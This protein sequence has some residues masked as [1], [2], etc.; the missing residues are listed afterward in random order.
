MKLPLPDMR[1]RSLNRLLLYFVGILATCSVLPAVALGQKSPTELVNLILTSTNDTERIAASSLLINTVPATSEGMIA[2]AVMEDYDNDEDEVIKTC[3]EILSQNPNYLPALMLL[4]NSLEGKERL[5]LWER[6]LQQEPSYLNYSALKGEYFAL[7]AEN[8]K[9]AEDFLNK[10]QQKLPNAYVFDFINGMA[11]ERAGQ[12]SEAEHFYEQA[13]SKGPD[14]FELYVRL[15]IL[16]TRNIKATSEE[17]ELKN[18]LQPVLQFAQLH[19]SSP[20]PWLF[21]GLRMLEAARTA[22]NSERENYS[23]MFGEKPNSQ[24]AFANFKRAFDIK[25]VAEY[26]VLAGETL[27]N[28]NVSHKRAVEVQQQ[29]Y[30]FMVGAQKKLPNDQLLTRYLGIHLSVFKNDS[31]SAASLFQQAIKDSQTVNDRTANV[32][33]LGRIYSDLTFEYDKGQA[34]FRSY[35]QNGGKK[36]DLFA[37]LYANRRDAGDFK[38][39]LAQLDDWEKY[40]RTILKQ[41]FDE[42]SVLARRRQIGNFLSPEQQSENFYRD[43]PFLNLWREKIGSQVLSINYAP[44][45]ASIPEKDYDLLSHAASLLKEQGANKYI[46]SIEGHADE[47][48]SDKTLSL[49]RSELVAQHFHEKFGIE[50]KRMQREGLGSDYPLDQT[51]DGRAKNR[52]VEILAIGN[53]SKPRISTTGALNADQVIALSPDG[54][55]L[56]TGN[57][58]IQLWDTREQIKL[59]DLGRGGEMLKFS[60]NGRY[61]ATTLDY[62]EVGGLKTDALIIYDVKTGLTMHQVPWSPL[63]VDPEASE[64][65]HFDWDPTSQRIV[66]TTP[67]NRIVI[68]DLIAKCNVKQRLA[69]G[70]RMNGG[71]PVLW[72]RDGKYIIAGRPAGSEL[73]VYNA[74]DLS[75]VKELPGVYWPHALAQTRDGKYI[76]ASSQST[77]KCSELLTVWNAADWSMRQLDIPVL[78]D[79]IAV[80]PGKHVVALNDF[81]CRCGHGMTCP[82]KTLLIDLDDLKILAEH[83][84]G[85]VAVQNS[86]SADGK[87]IYQVYED[88]IDLLDAG[89]PTLALVA[90]MK[91]L[92]VRP[93]GSSADLRNGHFLSADDNGF[94]VWSVVTGK[95]VHS[96]KESVKSFG[97][98]SEAPDVFLAVSED[99]VA[100]K[101]KILQFNTGEFAEKELLTLDFEVDKWFS[102]S[103]I[104]VFAGKPFLPLYRGALKGVVETYERRTM[105][106]RNRFEVPLVTVRQLEYDGVYDSGIVGLS[107]N[108][109]GTEISVST[110]WQDGF[111]HAPTS[112]SFVQRFDATTGKPAGVKR[113]SN[114]GI[115]GI[116]YVNGNDHQLAITTLLTTY[117]YDNP[118]DT[119]TPQKPRRPAGEERIDLKGGAQIRWSNGFLRYS[120]PAKGI[121]KEWSFN[122]NLVGVEVFEDRN[123]LVTLNNANE[124]SFFDLAKGEQ[125]LT[126]LSKNNDEWIAYTPAGE[127]LASPNGT[128]KVFWSLGDRNL[129]F[130]ALA[131]LNEK[132]DILSQKL[133]LISNCASTAKEPPEI[134]SLIEPPYSVEVLSPLSSQGPD[135]QYRLVLSVE[136]KEKNLPEPQFSFSQG[137][138]DLTQ[139][140]GT[141]ITKRPNSEVYDVER[142]FDLRDGKNDL[143]VFLNYRKT[144]QRQAHI[145]VRK[146]PGGGPAGKGD[147]WFLGIGVK[148]YKNQSDGLSFP[149]DDVRMIGDELQ[150]Q[151]SLGLYR[152]V[153][154]QIPPEN[155]VDAVRITTE[156]ANIQEKAQEND[157]VLIYLSGHGV[158]GAFS[159]VMFIPYNHDLKQPADGGVDMA[160]FHR[161]LA[162]PKNLKRKTMLWLDICR[163]GAT[164]EDRYLK[165]R[166]RLTDNDIYREVNG[167]TTIVFSSTTGSGS[168]T[169]GFPPT[170]KNGYFAMAILE[171]LTGSSKPVLGA[172]TG[173]FSPWDLMKYVMSRVP[174]AS[175]SKQQPS[176]IFIKNYQDW[177]FAVCPLKARASSSP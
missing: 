28:S 60:P 48:E 168:A 177:P 61:L 169:E 91:G 153:H 84:V 23:K 161:F 105:T 37:A 7:E 59:R 18:C 13:I 68:Y 45:S 56:A 120:M 143:E 65:S 141:K 34:L 15:A 159:A 42:E 76:V 172:E 109:K 81:G 113:L 69:P 157:T 94:H 21:I 47:T 93:I 146:T 2:R 82:R 173:K 43:N 9:V 133:D 55:L 57:Y 126:I 40:G 171:A 107:A 163:G 67:P 148:T 110:Y 5:E 129:E 85:E 33:S 26:A 121:T 149:V 66:Y 49:Q 142:V 6:I 35:L 139:P 31:A 170:Y 136:A 119:V 124:I 102:N 145:E 99:K 52:R 20:E 46:F 19:P 12:K 24:G 111:G 39:A 22:D 122:G 87:K 41:G 158:L 71:D 96:W 95:K 32:I 116:K 100:K 51:D 156:L 162:D 73:Q 86:F 176:I 151:K 16:R 70:Y 160:I 25:P 29:A 36:T 75:L 90:T 106:R 147:L 127:F 115:M 53:I 97:H 3:R 165:N 77:K 89:N 137:G 98:L 166:L 155:E 135:R 101:T 112:S 164:Q 30:D 132:P 80:H 104:V 72:T 88:K 103:E 54:R 118:S 17:K 123:L 140:E 175:P 150:R 138:Q 58:P 14:I 1:I 83:D 11:A 44:G 74:Q 154:V 131:A 108:S 50:M 64:H 125:E 78:A 144:V 38:G 10:W 27:L 134:Y 92:A 128:D 63:S 4:A 174:E 62:L 79:N 167:T 8:P 114:E 152:D 117:V 130:A